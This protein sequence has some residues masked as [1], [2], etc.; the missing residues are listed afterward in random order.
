MKFYIFPQVHRV[1]FLMSFWWVFGDCLLIYCV[2]NYISVEI[3]MNCW[4]HLGKSILGLEFVEINEFLRK[5]CEILNNCWICW[6]LLNFCDFCW[7]SVGFMLRFV[8]DSVEFWWVSDEML[9]T[10]LFLHMSSYMSAEILLSVCWVSVEFSAVS[11]EFLLSFCW[12]SVGFIWSVELLLSFC[13]VLLIVV[14]FC[15]L[16][17]EPSFWKPTLKLWNVYCWNNV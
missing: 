17:L 3:M 2:S 10:V 11:V 12:V 15:L 4:G 16:L 14:L 6:L 1:E 5:S 9:G 13:W 7:V 8:W